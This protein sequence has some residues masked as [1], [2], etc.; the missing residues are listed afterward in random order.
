MTKLIVGL[1]L[2]PKTSI[3]SDIV[4]K[5]DRNELWGYLRD[6]NGYKL[7]DSQFTVRQISPDENWKKTARQYLKTQ[8][9]CYSV[10]TET[11]A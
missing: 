6:Y 11:L 7:H 2:Q 10:Y 8:R 5:M 3:P 9:N 1:R 4:L